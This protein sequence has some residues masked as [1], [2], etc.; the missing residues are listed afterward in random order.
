M[1]NMVILKSQFMTAVGRQPLHA[2]NGT[3]F[4]LLKKVIAFLRTK[5]HQNV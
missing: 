3:N 2:T 4:C 5:T 1:S